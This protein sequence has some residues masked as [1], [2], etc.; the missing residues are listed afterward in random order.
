[1]PAAAAL[2]S[3]I[4]DGLVGNADIPDGGRRPSYASDGWTIKAHFRDHIPSL[5]EAV[6][7]LVLFSPI[8]GALKQRLLLI[9]RWRRSFG[10]H[11]VQSLGGVFRLST[12]AI[13]CKI[14]G[15]RRV[16]L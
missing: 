8:V 3:A 9:T 7:A 2:R 6:E 16:I 13:L 14:R 12:A 5:Q 1:M 15:A 11:G 4:T 10:I